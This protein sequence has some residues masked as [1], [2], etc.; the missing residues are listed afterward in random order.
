MDGFSFGPFTGFEQYIDNIA[1]S[2]SPL[3]SPFTDTYVIVG[4]AISPTVLNIQFDTHSDLIA[5]SSGNPL[6]G[7]LLSNS[8]VNDGTGD[9]VLTVGG[10]GNVLVANSG[11]SLGI[12]WA[13]AVVVSAPFTYTTATRTLT[14]ATATNSVAGVLSAADHTTFSAKQSST[15]TNTHILVGNAS[16]VATDVAMSGAVTITSTGVT[17]LT[18]ASVTGA[19]ITGF[20]SGAGVVAATDT[21]LQAIDKLN[22]NI[23]LKAPIASP[24]FTG[25]SSFAGAINSTIAQTTVSGSTSGSAVFSQPFEGSSYKKVIIYC[26]ALVGTASFT[27]PVAFAHNPVILTTNGLAATV[28]TALST[29]TVT[30]TGATTTGF[31]LIEGF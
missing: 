13:P 9:Q 7:G 18:A 11:A 28:I 20:V 19:L 22:G 14:A 31:L 2:I 1:G 10:N 23:A 5:N 27:F 21:I 25:T 8:A 26:N 6:K 15:L 4:M 30:V 24:S 29:T 3:P 12:S 17:S 16:N